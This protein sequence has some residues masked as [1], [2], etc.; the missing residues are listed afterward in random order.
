MDRQTNARTHDPTHDLPTGLHL[1]DI[2]ISLFYFVGLQVTLNHTRVGHG[3]YPGVWADISSCIVSLFVFGEA[4]GTRDRQ[5][6]RIRKTFS[7]DG[8]SD[9]KYEG[10][11]EDSD[12]LACSFIPSIINV[13]NI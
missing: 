2:T 5:L 10:E 11:C 8:N 12:F 7:F 4:N 9:K 6:I 3:C 1:A 13:C